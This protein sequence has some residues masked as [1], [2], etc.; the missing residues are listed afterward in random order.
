MVQMSVSP[1]GDAPYIRALKEAARRM[2]DLS[3]LM[4]SIGLGLEGSTRERFAETSRAPDGS[5]WEPSIEAIIEGRRTLV[6]SGNLADS[7]THRV[8]GNSVEVGSNVLYAAV[9]QFGATIAKKRAPK[10]IF[11]IAGVTYAADQVTIP[12]RPFLGISDDDAD[13][14]LEEATD[15]LG[16]AFGP[17]GGRGAS[18]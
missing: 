2:R 7:I 8:D 5:A 16:G 17:Q 14:I 18:S 4:G 10:L 12:A 11:R 13:M 1:E 6:K 3:P 9:H 15:F